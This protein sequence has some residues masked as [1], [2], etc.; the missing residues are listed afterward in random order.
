MPT[1]M[2]NLLDA[3]FTDRFELVNIIA[4]EDRS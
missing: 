3:K 1:A 2:F 4:F